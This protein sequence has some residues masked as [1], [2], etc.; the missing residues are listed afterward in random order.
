MERTTPGGNG[1]G[2]ADGAAAPASGTGDDESASAFLVTSDEDRPGSLL[3]TRHSSL[4][5]RL[6][7]LEIAVAELAHE[8]QRLAAALEPLIALSRQVHSTFRLRDR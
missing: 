2:A 6:E 1:G 8:Q 3:V 4:T 5:R 7:A